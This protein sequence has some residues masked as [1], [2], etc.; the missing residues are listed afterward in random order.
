MN[1]VNLT[2]DPV[3]HSRLQRYAKRLGRRTARAARDLVSEAL[4]RREAAELGSKLAADYAAGR[5][6]ARALLKDL[7]APQLDWLIGHGA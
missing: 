1:R 6:D 5:S 3:T 7:E 4:D 2:L